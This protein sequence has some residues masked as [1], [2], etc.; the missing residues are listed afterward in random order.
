MGHKIDI[1]LMDRGI[2]SVAGEDAGEFLQGLIT[3]D[4]NKVTKNSAIYAALLTPQGKYLYDF[5]VV[6]FEGQFLLDCK[7]ENIPGL[8][9]RLTMYRL[10]AKVT[11]ACKTSTFAVRVMLDID[12][13]DVS[14]KAGS[15]K[16]QVDSV[17]YIDP[18]HAE[19]GERTIQLIDKNEL[20]SPAKTLM[21]KNRAEYDAKRISL[22]IP[23]SFTDLIPQKSLPLEV[24]FDELNGVDF[25]K[26]CYVGQEVTARMKHRNLVKKRLFPITFD[27]EIASGTLVTA[28]DIHA[29]EIHSAQKGRG[30]A[31]LR[32]DV[33]ENGQL[34]ANGVKVTP[35]KPVWMAV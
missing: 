34:L 26:G 24:G 8:I 12:S 30:I 5:F 21:E 19:M 25:G 9:K 11:I 29:G 31:M 6:D 7:T 23:E 13:R 16:T 27:G 2:V 33:F 18:R 28:G 35:Q 3:N 4:I 32:L 20:S 17:S 22:G 1:P 15:A 10:R 14:A